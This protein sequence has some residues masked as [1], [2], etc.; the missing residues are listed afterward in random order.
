MRLPALAAIAAW[1]LWASAASAANLCNCCG[2]AGEG[3]CSAACAAIAVPAG[4]CVA[5]VDYDSPAEVGAGINPLY[6]L[7]LRNVRL[8]SPNREQLEAFRQLLERARIGA[9]SDR[10][11]AL[12]VRRAG[13]TGEATADSSAIRYETA[14]VNYYLGILSYRDIAG[15]YDPPPSAVAFQPKQACGFGSPWVNGYGISS[16]LPSRPCPVTFEAGELLTGTV[17]APQRQ[18]EC[19]AAP[20]FIVYGIWRGRD[21]EW[22]WK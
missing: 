21:R 22:C 7:S 17:G 10:R 20:R 11:E 13:S 4:Q 15:T 16:I 19:P 14:M 12:D 3:A 6:G 2:D 8:G 9:E 18:T 1:V 5:A